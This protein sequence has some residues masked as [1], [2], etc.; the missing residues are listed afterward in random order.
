MADLKVSGAAGHALVTAG[1]QDPEGKKEW[2]YTD[3]ILRYTFDMLAEYEGV[4]TKRFDNPTGK[5]E[6]SLPERYN[7][8]NK[9]GA[10][11]H[12]DFHLNAYGSGGW[13]SP[14]GTECYVDPSR[15]K[16]AVEL[17]KKIQANLVRELGFN[18]RGVKYVAFDMVHF[19]KMT[20]VLPEIAFM[21][22]KN[23]AYKMRT[24]EY[25]KKAAKAI[26]DALVGQYRLKKKPV[27]K[28]APKPARPA[29]PSNNGG[30]Y[31]VQVGAFT[32]K[33]NAERLAAELKKKGYATFITQE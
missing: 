27:P 13:T 5:R 15:P 25:Q 2:W 14:G 6:I 24:A 33:S 10:D 30:L 26:V 20:A 3:K 22:N 31:K 7:A 16:E 17:A 32:E 8:I 12:I 1:K 21:T 28:P 4:V 18:N 19:T 9:W 29:K 23:E 11:V